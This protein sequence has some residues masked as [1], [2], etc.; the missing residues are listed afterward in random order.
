MR[1]V[2]EVHR[3]D[4]Q[5]RLD[6]LLVARLPAAARLSRTRLAAWIR[7]GRVEVDGVPATRASQ[8]LRPGQAI[9]LDLPDAPPRPHLAEDRPLAVLY[10]D[11]A[12][13]AIDK[14]AGLVMH[15]TRR[16]PSGTLTNALLA[17]LA[18][19]GGGGGRVHLVHRLDRETSGCLLVARTRLAAATLARTFQTRSARKIYWALVYG[20]PRPAQ[21][22]VSTYL[23]R[24]AGPDGDM[25]VVAKHGEKDAQHAVTYYSTVEHAGGRLSWLTMKPTTGRTHQLRVHCQAIGHPIIGDPRYF[26]IENWDL[27]GGIQNR[28][29]L[30]A[31]RLT[32]PHPS[33]QG[34]IDVTAPLPPHMVQSWNL[35]G[36]QAELD[37]DD[38]DPSFPED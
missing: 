28:L 25:M 9:A 19:R 10:E 27:P 29:H 5:L 30:L 3:G 13:L 2:L 14:P 20:Q 38:T 12:L 26:D 36:F 37:G 7:D 16:Y 17:H 34:T 35:L 32:I 18:I 24:V 23:K 31:R 22:K 11:D 21:G 33:G 15:P 8:R 1:R 6:R 4:A